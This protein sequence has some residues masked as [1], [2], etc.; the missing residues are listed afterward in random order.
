MLAAEAASRV[1]AVDVLVNNAGDS[2]SAPFRKIPLE[3]WNRVMAVNATGTFLCTREVAPA[4]IERKFGRIVNVASLAGISGA[5]YVAHYS[6]AKHAVIGFTRSV[7]L[8]LEGSGV[9]ANAVCPGYVDT[10]MTARTISNVAERSGMPPAEALAA[11]LATT[12]Q[13]RLQTTAEVAQ[14]VLALCTGSANGQAVLLG[15]IP[16]ASRVDGGGDMSQEI[17]NPESLGAPKGFSHGVLAPAGRTLYVAGQPGWDDNATGARPG[18]PEQFAR[19]LDRVLAVVRQAGG[20]PG[21]IT[22]LTAYVTDLAAYRMARP[23]LGKVWGERFGQY[24]PAM[25]LVEVKGLVDRGAIV[26][27]EATAVLGG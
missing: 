13:S 7:A 10:P 1:G 24:Y 9:T 25:A 4:M 14:Q 18:F 19:A 17:V 20:K 12:G 8:E 23:A 16:T 2:S 27:I 3:E 21:D 5:R 11:V 26:E 15:G 6:A 22:R